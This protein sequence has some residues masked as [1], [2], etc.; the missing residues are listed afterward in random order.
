[1]CQVLRSKKSWPFFKDCVCKHICIHMHMYVQAYIYIHTHRHTQC[2]CS[3]K[4]M[5][6]VY[7]I[8]V[9]TMYVHN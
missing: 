9:N 7:I 8:Y 4:H 5:L 1:M 2:K 6:P 3:C